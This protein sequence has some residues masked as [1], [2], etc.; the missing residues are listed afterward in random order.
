MHISW[1]RSM[2]CQYNFYKYSREHTEQQLKMKDE[3]IQELGAKLQQTKEESSR[4]RKIWMD[5]V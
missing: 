3:L 1:L 5:K 4:D 2:I